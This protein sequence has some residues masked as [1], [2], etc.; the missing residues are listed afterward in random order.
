[1]IL[2]LSTSSV[3]DVNQIFCPLCCLFYHHA[4][5][6]PVIEN[7]GGFV[8]MQISG[9]VVLQ[10]RETIS[11]ILNHTK[12][13][14]STAHRSAVLLFALHYELDHAGSQ[15]LI[16]RAFWNYGK[17]TNLKLIPTAKHSQM[18]GAYRSEI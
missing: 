16:Y 14:A 17:Q 1:M 10:G 8:C 2:S 11:R 12:G 9:S 13:F 5:M 7:L 18:A 4:L 15:C 6:F 3:Q